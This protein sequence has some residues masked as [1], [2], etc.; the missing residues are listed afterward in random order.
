[1]RIL[2]AEDEEDMNRI[3]TEA[4]REEKYLVDSCRNGQDA[5]DCL[6]TSEYDAVILDVMMPIRDGYDV[7]KVIRQKKPETPVLFLT[8]KDAVEERVQ[9]LDAGANDYLVKPFSL[10][11][12]MARVRVMTRHNHALSSSILRCGDL[13]L[14]P[15][16]HVVKRGGR[17]MDLT[18]KEYQLL[19]Y[20]M[21]NKGVVL[22]RSRIEDHI[23]D[24]SYVGGTNVVDVYIGYLRQKIDKDFDKKLIKTKRGMGYLLTDE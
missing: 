22:S 9:G 10:D 6:E 4:L 13:E 2:Y 20:M 23:W 24:Y 14:D 8:A 18:A 19:E 21:Y 5:I 15:G 1:M 11:E 17:V 16:A 3:V 12:L 7:L